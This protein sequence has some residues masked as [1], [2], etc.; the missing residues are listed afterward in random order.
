MNTNGVM[1]VGRDCVHLRCSPT[2]VMLGRWVEGPVDNMG[3]VMKTLSSGVAR[4]SPV[5]LP[6]WG[7][8]DPPKEW[9]EN[10]YIYFAQI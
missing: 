5:R 10:I 1:W 4:G 6:G 9:L 8:R 2:Q 7:S 3:K